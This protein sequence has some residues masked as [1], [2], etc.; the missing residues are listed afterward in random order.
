MTTTATCELCE[1]LDVGQF[2]ALAQPHRLELLIGLAHASSEGRSV[3]EIA[4]ESPL[5]TSVVSRHLTQL[6]EAGF[7]RATRR[8][9]SVAYSVDPG[10]LSGVLRRA[11]DALDRC[12]DG[13]CSCGCSCAP[14]CDCGCGVDA[15]CTCER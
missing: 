3:G 1:R 13:L 10:V 11:A 6:R 8:G 14:D 12:C 15:P 4:G 5:D 9:R 7:V 2:K